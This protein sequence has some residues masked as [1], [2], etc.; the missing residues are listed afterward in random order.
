MTGA[1]QPLPPVLYHYT[2]AYGLVGIIKK[3]P[4]PKVFK[5][6]EVM[7]RKSVK[8]LASDIRYM[9][10]TEELKFGVRLIRKHLETA[11]APGSGH[12]QLFRLLMEQLHSMFNPDQL[13]DWGL[14]AFASCLCK[15]DDLLSQWRGYAGGTGGFAIG[16]NFDAL[17]GRSYTFDKAIGPHGDLGKTELLPVIYGDEAEQYASQAIDLVRMRFDADGYIADGRNGRVLPFFPALDIFRAAAV[18]KHRAF[19]EEKEWRLFSLSEPHYPA[20]VAARRRGLVPYAE[21][22]VNVSTPDNPAVKTTIVDLVVGPCPDQDAQ[23]A[24]AAELLQANGHDPKVVR[25]SDAP[26]RG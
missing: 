14:R 20:A 2:D 17:N 3:A 15:E 26:F 7:Y 16:L 6:P 22:D 10:D 13:F 21:I 23:V 9:N 1:E 8:L 12:G 24:A 18:M 4:A 19:E 5:D 11:S 25:K